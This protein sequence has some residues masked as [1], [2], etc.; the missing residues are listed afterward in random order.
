MNG[1]IQIN[2]LG[3]PNVTF[4]VELDAT[5]LPVLPARDLIGAKD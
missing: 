3:G 1:K 5:K 2:E 4:L